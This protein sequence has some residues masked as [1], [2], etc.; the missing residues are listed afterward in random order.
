MF[1]AS[2]FLCVLSLLWASQTACTPPGEVSEKAWGSL[3]SGEEVTL[4]TLTNSLGMQA[5]ITNYGGIVVSLTTPDRDG[6][7]EDVV[8]G[9]ST[10]AKY[11]ERNPLFGAIVGLYANRIETGLVELDGEQVQLFVREEP[12]RILVHIHGGSVGLD[13]VVWTGESGVEQ[14]TAF[15]KLHYIHADGMDGYPGAVNVTVTYRLTN[16]NALKID[17]SSTTEKTTIINLTN[18]SYFNLIGGGVGN[19]LNHEMQLES[20]E[21]TE[22]KPGLIPTGRF[23]S[24]AGT[25]FDFNSPKR[26][27]EH[28]DDENGQL[29]LG[30]GYDHNYVIK[31]T[32]DRV[33]LFATVYEP[34]SGRVME[35]FTDQ[36]GVQFYTANGMRNL[37]G[38]G[39]VAYQPRSGFCLET[40]HYP[41]SPNHAHFPSTI[42]K[43]GDVFKSTT[44]FKFSAR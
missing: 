2:A 24:V 23:V 18:H 3:P 30:R 7:L 1:R 9:Y 43:P 39:D 41:D 20:S 25:P 22:V 31:K 6:V 19:V 28:I 36:P 44:V 10:L 4:Y 5:D 17:Y 14:S 21:L 29:R 13:Q 37:V 11:V 32:T 34:T 16:D 12:G 42:L 27:G 35:A 38:K 8:L 33:E 40:Q 15:L 26:I